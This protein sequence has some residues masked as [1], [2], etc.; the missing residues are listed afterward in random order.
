MNKL[1]KQHYIKGIGVF[2]NILYLTSPL[3]GIG[4]SIINAITFYAV[5]YPYIHRILPWFNFAVFIICLFLGGIVLLLSFYKFVYPS[6]YEFLN[7]QTLTR[8]IEK[9]LNRIEKKLGIEDGE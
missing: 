1:F 2:I 8:Q 4:M 7:R 9:R 6:Y 3:I 5:V